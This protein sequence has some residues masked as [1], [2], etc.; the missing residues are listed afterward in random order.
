MRAFKPAIGRRLAQ[1]RETTAANAV[2]AAPR[3]D[4]IHPGVQ[5]YLREQGL[6]R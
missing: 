3:T 6:L 1:A 2:A 5:R 4:L